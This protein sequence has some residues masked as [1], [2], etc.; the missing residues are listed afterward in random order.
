MRN[1]GNK[2][3]EVFR[4]EDETLCFKTDSDEG[5]FCCILNSESEF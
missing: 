5:D 1:P 2:V 3:V 4:F